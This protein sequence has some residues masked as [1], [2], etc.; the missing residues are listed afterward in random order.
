MNKDPHAQWLGPLN[1]GTAYIDGNKTR[2]LLDDGSQIN[3]V[4]LAYAKAHD[5]G[6]GPLEVLAGDPTGHPIQGIGGVCTGAIRYVVFQVQIDGIP[7]YNEVQ[8]ALVVDNESA[9]ARKV[10]I[11]LG[12]PTLHHVVNCMKESEMEK[13]PLQWE[14]VHLGY[15][16]HNRLCSH[17]ANVEPDEPF[18]T[19]TGQ[20]STDLDE[21]VRLSKPVVV[22]AF[23]S[24]IVKGLTNETIIMG[25][26]LNIM[27]QAPYREDEANL[28][29]RLYVLRNY[30]EMKDRSRLVY[31]VLRNGTS[32]PIRLSGG[33]LIR[34]VVTVNLVPKAEASPELMRELGLEED[35]WKEPKLTIP[36]WQAH[37]MEILGKNGDLTILED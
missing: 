26:R 9:F 33:R 14:N 1:L 7:S 17:Q 8:V 36:E 37:L 27:T 34:R 5:L 31:L 20:D 22:P 21:V 13:A 2:V 30:C 11:I 6:V 16:V 32:Q 3:S 18:P 10:L 28:P 29:V 24:T 15:K 35:K 12:T 25:H 23:G 4:M 19:N